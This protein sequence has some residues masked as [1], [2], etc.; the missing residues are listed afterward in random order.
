MFKAKNAAYAR[1]LRDQVAASRKKEIF[2]GEILQQESKS[3][4][5]VCFANNLAF[6]KRLKRED[7][8]SYCGRM[9]RTRVGKNGSL[10]FSFV[11][12]LAA[13]QLQQ[14]LSFQNTVQSQI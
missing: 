6:R 7:S 4:C 8:G 13:E 11:S 9:D 1:I 5:F 3:L 12:F 10:W 2:V 14:S